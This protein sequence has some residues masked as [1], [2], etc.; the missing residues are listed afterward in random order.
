[1]ASGG[2]YV[3]NASVVGGFK[4]HKTMVQAT[5]ERELEEVHRRERE[6]RGSRPLPRIEGRTV[7]LVDD[8]LATGS[9]MH[10]A[11]RVLRAE[12]A[13]RVVVAVPVGAEETCANFRDEVDEIVCA[14]T[15]DPFRAVGLWYD[16]FSQTS[17]EEVREL[18]RQAAQHE[19]TAAKR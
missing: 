7:I 2:M 4:I 16:D 17:N 3:L 14:A 12:K 18:L 6:Y 11:V 9:T 8:G 15:P 19:P 10:A 13:A 5:A 1:M